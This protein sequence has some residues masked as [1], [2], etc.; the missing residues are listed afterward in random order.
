[1]T[2]QPNTA[3]AED[4]P[5]SLGLPHP[6]EVDIIRADRGNGCIHFFRSCSLLF[7]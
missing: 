2:D 7:N 5:Q 6:P 1:M 4:I 3:L